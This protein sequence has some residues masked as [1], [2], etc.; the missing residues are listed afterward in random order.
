MVRDSPLKISFTL[1]G[2]RPRFRRGAGKGFEYPSQAL[3]KRSKS[4]R[5]ND[6]RRIA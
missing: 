5:I 6:R 4:F 2:L 3:R 1:K